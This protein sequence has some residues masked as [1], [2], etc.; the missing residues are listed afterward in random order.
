LRSSQIP[1]LLSRSIGGTDPDQ[2]TDVGATLPD[3]QQVVGMNRLSPVGTP[4]AK[5]DGRADTIGLS[6]V[7]SGFP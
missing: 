2:D 7:I 1:C 4:A 6:S 5:T 3:L